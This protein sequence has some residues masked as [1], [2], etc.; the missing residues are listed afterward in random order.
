M[1]YSTKVLIREMEIRL[2]ALKYEWNLSLGKGPCVFTIHDCVEIDL[3]HFYGYG[4]VKSNEK[5]YEVFSGSH[6]GAPTQPLVISDWKIFM[7]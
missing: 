3:L 2:K 6:H 1:L 5:Y 4:G 7:I